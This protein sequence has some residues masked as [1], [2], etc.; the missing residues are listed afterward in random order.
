MPK[1]T[2]P[3][4]LWN[5]ITELQSVGG[6]QYEGNSIA[7]ETLRY[8]KSDQGIDVE[9]KNRLYGDGMDADGIEQLE[10]LPLPVSQQSGDVVEDRDKRKSLGT[11]PISNRGFWEDINFNPS[12][13]QPYL[14]SDLKKTVKTS[15]VTI[16]DADGSMVY[17]KMRLPDQIDRDYSIDALPFVTDPNNENEI[18][19]VDKYYDKEINSNEYALATEGKINYYLYPRTSGRI[20]PDLPIDIFKSRNRKASSDNINRFDKAAGNRIQIKGEGYFLFNL[21][22]G[23]DTQKEY[24]DKPKLL[25]GSVMFDHIYE[26]PGFYTITGTVF[27]SYGFF[28]RQ[29]EKF[30]TRILLNPSKKY[31]EELDLFRH[32][33]FAMIGGISPSSTLVKSVSSMVGLDPF[34]FSNEKTKNDLLTDYNELD[35]IE[36]LNLMNM[37][38]SN[39]IIDYE[40]KYINPYSK[41]I[42]DEPTSVLEIP[43]LLGCMDPNAD[44]YVNYATLNNGC[45]YSYLITSNISGLGGQSP[46]FFVGEYD[47]FRN[48]YLAGGAYADWDEII[49]EI[50]S[51]DI[52]SNKF[53]LIVAPSTIYPELGFSDDVPFDGWTIPDGLRIGKIN[54]SDEGTPI[55]HQTSG[56]DLPD[57]LSGQGFGYKVYTPID[58]YS[59]VDGGDRVYILTLDPNNPPSETNYTDREIL[60]NWS[61]PLPDTGDLQSGLGETLFYATIGTEVLDGDGTITYLE[62]TASGQ[63]GVLAGDIIFF[64]IS[65]SANQN[66]NHLYYNGEEVSPGDDRIV[67]AFNLSS[68]TSLSP[69]V[70]YQTSNTTGLSTWAEDVR[71][72]F[73]IEAETDNRVEAIFSEMTIEDELFGDD[74]VSYDTVNVAVFNSPATTGTGPSGV[75]FTPQST[76]I[77]YQT[78][79]G[80]PTQYEGSYV[81]NYQVP[82]EYGV[83]VDYNPNYNSVSTDYVV[84]TNQPINDG[85]YHVKFDRNFMNMLN[86]ELPT[87]STEAGF[88][89]SWMGWFSKNPNDPTF[90]VEADL[91]STDD[92]YEFYTVYNEGEGV[93]NE[94]QYFPTLIDGET[95]QQ[96]SG[97]DYN[98]GPVLAIYAFVKY[99][100]DLNLSR[101]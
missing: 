61:G 64:Y 31:L 50:S 21:D 39:S 60:A 101:P 91:L 56:N 10:T 88:G 67:E 38:S 73:E 86:D 42:D 68:N 70:F 12:T 94:E 85:P 100:P 62:L 18:I 1:Y 34:D 55:I 6:T 79:A 8:V 47:G 46:L 54:Y 82:N 45:E 75:R 44:N 2:T 36:L 26:K 74:Y 9:Y 20:L 87:E 80:I 81:Y 90:D 14:T 37:I 58:L 24:T 96:I 43:E 78:S 3:Q 27:L 59:D 72:T 32:R 30:E 53:A 98:I 28:V 95:F 25:E 83:M 65:P 7:N 57:T 69:D 97:G 15:I 11:F 13:L 51:N 16:P 22:W 48:Y 17:K 52:T 23:D 41:I 49:T 29:Y 84:A 71:Y 35:R 92:E 40:E 19:R 99:E 5:T 76:L 77:G 93:N 4:A 89:Y 66:I 33:N 63:D